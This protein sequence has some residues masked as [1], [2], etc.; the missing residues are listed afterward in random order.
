AQL[1]ERAD[2]S[3]DMIGK[4]ERGLTGPSYESLEV[5]AKILN[6]PEAALFSP[7]VMILPTGERGRI[8][9]KINLHLSKMN[10]D[11]LAKGERV[12]AALAE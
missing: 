4:I 6:I 8:L 9:K 10:E 7:S 2:L 12:L 5:L 11:A 3:T 1:A